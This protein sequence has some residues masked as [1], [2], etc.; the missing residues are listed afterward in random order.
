MTTTTSR[1]GVREGVALTSLFEYHVRKNFPFSVTYV[2]LSVKNRVFSGVS[3]Y[4]PASSGNSHSGCP[5]F[6]ASALKSASRRSA[7]G[8]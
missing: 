4:S 6:A 2:P 8:P 1:Q 5:A 7:I 3:L